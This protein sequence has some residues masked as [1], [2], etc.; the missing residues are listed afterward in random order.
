SV[1][2]EQFRSKLGPEE[3]VTWAAK[4]AGPDDKAAIAEMVATL[5]DESL[6]AFSGHFW[7][8]PFFWFRQE[9]TL[10]SPAHGMRWIHP[11][12]FGMISIHKKSSNWIY[13]AFSDG[14]SSICSN[15]LFFSMGRG[16]AYS[17]GDEKDVYTLNAFEVAT[18]EGEGFLA[19]STRE[20]TRIGTEQSDVGFELSVI[21]HGVHSD[22][23]DSSGE[24]PHASLDAVHARKNLQETAFFY[25]HLLSDEDGTIRIEFTMPEALTR[26]KFLGLA[27]DKE[28][29]SGLLTGTAITS[30]D[31]MVQPNPP[32]FVREGDRI[33]F[34]VKVTNRSAEL[35]SGKVRLTFADAAT[36]NP[37]DTDL[38]N[39]QPELPFEIPAGESRTCSWDITVPDGMGFLTYKAVGAS[40]NLSDGE[41]AYLPVLSR[42]ILLTESIPLPIR[43]KGTREFNFDKLLASS[44][45]DTLRHQ[46]LKVQ[47]VSQP[48]WYAVMALPYLMEYPHDCSEQIFSRL[49]ANALAGHIANSDPKIRRV[50]DLWRESSSLESPLFQNEDLKGV[51]IEDTPW[52]RDALGESESRKQLGLLFE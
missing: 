10:R 51:M 41:E 27:H 14:I 4:I 25:P 39:L 47:M 45:S 15:D 13:P 43:G 49:Y 52:M 24:E 7:S 19:T 42:S 38:G 33:A 30:K 28:L 50:F 44:G 22:T 40:A 5:Y 35:I 11:L 31:L 18:P 23:G 12:S 36:L 46:S 21:T 17:S 3:T 37:V 6:D 34:P 2:W 9:K 48:A 29:R 1:K 32:R 8:F 16:A 26:W 20:R